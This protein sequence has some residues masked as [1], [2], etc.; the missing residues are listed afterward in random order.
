MSATLNDIKQ[1]IADA[2]EGTRFVII[3]HDIMDYSPN[4][5]Y[6]PKGED[7]K[8][9]HEDYCNKMGSWPADE[10][11]D[12]EMDLEFQLKERRAN[13]WG[14][15]KKKDKISIN[16]GDHYIDLRDNKEVQVTHIATHTE[17]N[18]TI[19]VFKKDLDY[20]YVPIDGWTELLNF[21]NGERRLR[22]QFLRIGRG[23]Q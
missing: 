8:K 6:V 9:W 1:M 21:D 16:T 10:C 15:E 5:L 18:E 20:Y 22:F 12:L 17:T 13:H 4:P 14:G 7:P 23:S 19:V 11:Y 2:P 3:T